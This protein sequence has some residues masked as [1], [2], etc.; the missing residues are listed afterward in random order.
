M[1]ILTRRSLV[2]VM[3]KMSKMA[4]MPA[5]NVKLTKRTGRT[6]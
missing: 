6:F 4:L 2:Q 1:T 5:N 3:V